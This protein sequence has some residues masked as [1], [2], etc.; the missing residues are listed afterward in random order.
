MSVL[1]QEVE[2]S[3]DGGRITEHFAVQ[4]IGH[5]PASSL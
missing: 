1:Q 2:Y 4:D 3:A 5:A